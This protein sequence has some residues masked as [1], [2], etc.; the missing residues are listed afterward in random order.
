MGMQDNDASSCY[1]HILAS[2]ALLARI[3]NVRWFFIALYTWFLYANN[4]VNSSKLMN[5]V[6]SRSKVSSS[7]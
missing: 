4:V 7:K 1:H 6:L 5:P 3:S 2:V